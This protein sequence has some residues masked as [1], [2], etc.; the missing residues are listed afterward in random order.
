MIK[1]AIASGKGGTG[2]TFLATN[3]FTIMKHSGFSV[4]MTDCDA[5]VP[6]ALIFVKGEKMGE[7]ETKVLC[8][9]INPSECTFCAL[10]AENCGF[11]AISCVPAAKYI[12]VSSE[13]CH[14][15]GACLIEC[16]YHAVEEAWKV[17]GTVTAYGNENHP[18]LF[19]ARIREGERSPVPVIREAIRKS[20]ESGAE[21]LILD[22]PPGCSCPF[23][24]TVMDADMVIL[25]TEPTPFGLSDL[26]HTVEVLRRLDKSFGVVINRADIG[27][28]QMKKWLESERIELLAEIPYSERIATLYAKGKLAIELEPEIKELFTNLMKR[29]IK[30]EDSNR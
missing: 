11:N 7:W 1:I 20:A 27:D 14:G 21:Y 19:E 23:V 2:K 30:H 12:K 17:I 16:P 25:V 29:I 15:C 24:N 5:D 26:K 13:L 3:L 4:V 9:Q 18:Q 8:P 6:N 28:G 10:C 22:A